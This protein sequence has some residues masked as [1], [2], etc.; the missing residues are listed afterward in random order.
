MVYRK[1][2][3][4]TSTNKIAK[5]LLNTEKR[6]FSSLFSK[7]LIGI[8]AMLWSIP[9]NAQTNYWQQHVIYRMDVQLNVATNIITGR[10]SIVYTNNSPDTLKKLFFSLY[11]NAFQPNSMMDV[12]SRS[13]E[14]LVVGRDAKGKDVTDF[15]S[16]FKYRIPNMTPAEQGHC[17]ITSLSIGGKNQQLKEQETVLEVVLDNPIL[18]KQTVTL[19]TEFES[20]VPRLSRRSGRDNQEGGRYSLGHFPCV[21]RCG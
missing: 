17:H 21:R 9:N 19:N 12:H 15:D 11:Y 5:A 18:P 3:V 7:A 8:V 14:F 13:T 16:R 6:S 2:M 10:Q 20:Q 4:R 1:D